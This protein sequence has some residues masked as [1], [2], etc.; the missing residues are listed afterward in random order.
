MPQDSLNVNLQLGSTIEEVKEYLEDP[1][2]TLARTN[3]GLLYRMKL[4][5]SLSYRQAPGNINVGIFKNVQIDLKFPKGVL[6]EKTCIKHESLSLTNSSTPPIEQ[7]LLYAQNHMLPHDL[8][9]EAVLTYQQVK[10]QQ[11]GASLLRTNCNSVLMPA[12]FFMRVVEPSKDSQDFKLQ[13][14]MR[15]GQSIGS[16]PDVFQSLLNKQIV[17]DNFK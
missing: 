3:K 4:K 16:L 5:V 1:Q 2:N 10:D 11:K 8:H 9:V 15:N 6:S 7:I 13:L 14:S 12:S 17:D